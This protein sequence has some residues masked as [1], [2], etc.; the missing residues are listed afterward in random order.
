MQKKQIALS[1]KDN[2]ITKVTAA[3]YSPNLSRS[4]KAS[5]GFAATCFAV[6]RKKMDHSLKF[7]CRD[8]TGHGGS[9]AAIEFSDDGTLLASGGE[10]QIV[11]LWPLSKAVEDGRNVSI[12]PI[13]ME[14]MH[15]SRV[16]CLALSSD[17]E[18]LFSGDSLGQVFIHDVA[19]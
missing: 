16:C 14:D 1:D 10:D 15:E 3:S 6:H 2:Q 11:R 19:M 9:I 7:N 5:G 13:E 12:V 8:L 4:I 18:R 17:N